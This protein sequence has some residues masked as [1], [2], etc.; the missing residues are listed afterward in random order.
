MIFYQLFTRV[1]YLTLYIFKQCLYKLRRQARNSASVQP[2]RDLIDV[3]SNFIELDDGLTVG[4]GNRLDVEIETEASD[5]FYF[6]ETGRIGALDQL[7][8]LSITV[9]DP[10]LIPPTLNC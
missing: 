8:I 2:A 1:G 3:R 10:V 9:S 7:L 5:E 6:P 4:G